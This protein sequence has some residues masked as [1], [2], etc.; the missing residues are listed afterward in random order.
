MIKKIFGNPQAVV[1]LLMIVI[2]II[3][4]LFAPSI[5]PNDPYEINPAMKDRKSVV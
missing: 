4:A 5:A 2:V 3:C 1:G